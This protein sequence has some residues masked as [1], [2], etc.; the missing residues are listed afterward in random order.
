MNYQK[1]NSRPPTRKEAAKKALELSNDPTFK[2]SK[3]WLDKF[4]RKNS[5]EFT[6]L[7]IFPS[8]KKRSELGSQTSE[9]ASPS[10]ESLSHRSHHSIGIGSCSTVNEEKR[11]SMSTDA[12]SR[13]NSTKDMGSINLLSNPGNSKH[14]GISKHKSFFANR[15]QSGPMTLFGHGDS[16]KELIPESD[17]L[18]QNENEEE[19]EEQLPKSSAA[20]K[21]AAFKMQ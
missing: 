21:R 16:N 13:R 1:D 8:R 14:S 12:S 5:I 19:E 4:S 11:D 3:G 10:I 2:A 7:K 20:N 17:E 6:P 15:S 18:N 9:D